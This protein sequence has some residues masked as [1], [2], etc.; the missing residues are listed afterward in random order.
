MCSLLRSTGNAGLWD[1]SPDPPT[2]EYDAMPL[3]SIGVASA[4][5]DEVGT[6]STT[7]L[8]PLD[9]ALGDCRWL[10]GKVVERSCLLRR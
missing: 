5:L 3:T 1:G 9:T 6:S 8:T 2:F 7:I 4:N 10:E